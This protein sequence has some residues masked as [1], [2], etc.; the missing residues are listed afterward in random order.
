MYSKPGYIQLLVTP[1]DSLKADEKCGAVYSVKCD[2]CDEEY[3]GEIGK[4]LSTN[5]K[6]QK[7][8]VLNKKMKSALGEHIPKKTRSKV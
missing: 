3:V 2:T 6:E 5:M 1:K 4:P 8:L 7:L